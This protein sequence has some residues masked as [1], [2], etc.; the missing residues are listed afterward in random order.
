MA[1]FQTL[2]GQEKITALKEDIVAFFFSAT[3]SKCR[4]VIVRYFQLSIYALEINWME[5]G[6][7]MEFLQVLTWYDPQNGIFTLTL[8]PVSLK[9]ILWFT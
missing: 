6:L 1:Y 9:K 4:V 3:I 2:G 7:A 8:P 5:I